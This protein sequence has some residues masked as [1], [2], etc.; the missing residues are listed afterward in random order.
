MKALPASPLPVARDDTFAWSSRTLTVA[1]MLANPAP[2]S[3]FESD[4]IVVPSVNSTVSP[5]TTADPALPAPLVFDVTVDRA[6]STRKPVSETSPATPSP[7][8]SDRRVLS[9]MVSR[10]SLVTKMNPESSPPGEN[11]FAAMPT[12][13]SSTVPPNSPTKPAEPPSSVGPEPNTESER[14]V[15]SEI[16]SNPPAEAKTP[17][18]LPLPWVSEAHPVSPA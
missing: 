6:I 7:K 8:V 13:L 16:A 2:P 3:A 12:R 18:A 1:E 15:V 5:F 10:P 17:P 4:E 11:V 9:A 14:M